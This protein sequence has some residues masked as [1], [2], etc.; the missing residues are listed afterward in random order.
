MIVVAAVATGFG[1][2]GRWDLAVWV[3]VVAA[4]YLATTY[5]LSRRS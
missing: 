1:A 2:A 4:C 5:V 3:A